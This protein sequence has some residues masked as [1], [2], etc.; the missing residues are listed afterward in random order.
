MRKLILM[1]VLLVT[2]VAPWRF[3]GD[4]RAPR[5]MRRTV[6]FMVL[7]L[8]AWAVCGPRLFFLVPPPAD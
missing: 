4:P 3:A 8:V 5:G 6:I 1:S 2:V 7:F